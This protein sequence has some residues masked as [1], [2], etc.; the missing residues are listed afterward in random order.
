MLTLSHIA[1]LAEL[2]NLIKEPTS[3]SINMAPLTGLRSARPFEV[4]AR[5]TTVA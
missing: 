3:S 2:F 5:E 4:L 1:L